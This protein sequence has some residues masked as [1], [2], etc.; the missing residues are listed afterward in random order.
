MTKQ[1]ILIFSLS[2]MFFLTASLVAYSFTEPTT[3]PSSY[4]PPINTGST[5][6][7]KAGEIGASLFRDYN[8]PN[9]YV[10]P[11]GLTKLSKTYF[12][13][14]GGDVNQDG[15]ADS[16]DVMIILQYLAGNIKLGDALFTTE[17]RAEADVN[18][19]GSIDVLDAELI[20]NM[21]AGNYTTLEEAQLAGKHISDRAIDIDEDG[22]VRIKY[23]G[24]G[25]GDVNGDGN[26]QLGDAL[27]IVQYVKGVRDFTDEQRYNADV[28]GDNDVDVLDA[29]MIASLAMDQPLAEVRSHAR[30]VKDR[31]IDVDGDGNIQFGGNV[32][33]V[34][35]KNVQVEGD[36][37]LSNGKCLSELLNRLVFGNHSE[38]D[39]T[40]AGGTVVYES[41]STMGFCKFSSSTCPSGWT[42][43]KNWSTTVASAIHSCTCQGNGCCSGTQTATQGAN[44]NGWADCGGHTP[45][46]GSHTWSDTPVETTLLGA[47]AGYCACYDCCWC[48]V[49]ATVTDIGCY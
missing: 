33:N 31:A 8:N 47:R 15:V 7:S 2:A 29:T 23:W 14:G 24:G 36:V 5:T 49:N 1:K 12:K 39:C 43:Y 22:Y 18:G 25:S 4:N 35:A 11:S 32:G 38:A 27:L 16:T 6:Q 3:M 26:V 34:L 17:T 40:S 44:I 37:C 41:G 28:N 42:Q 30:T 19:D 48:S 20:L 21:V 46:F 9:Y 10:D 13:G 45:V